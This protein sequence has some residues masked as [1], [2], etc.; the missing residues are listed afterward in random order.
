MLYLINK[1]SVNMFDTSEGVSID[2]IPLTKEE[3]ENALDNNEYKSVITKEFFANILTDEL[4]HYIKHNNELV[5]IDDKAIL[6][7]YKGPTVKE[8]ISKLPRDA[9]IL[10]FLVKI[11]ND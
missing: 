3:V 2:I 7:Y 4:N 10:F 5:T 9:E 8:G 6:F 11:I 1:L